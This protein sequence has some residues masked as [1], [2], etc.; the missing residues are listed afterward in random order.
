MRVY[1]YI[2]ICVS[3]PFCRDSFERT[4]P[5]P[6]GHRSKSCTPTKHPNP[7]TKLGSKMGG[8]FTD[9]PTWDPKAV[10][11]GHIFPGATPWRQVPGSCDVLQLGVR[12]RPAAMAGLLLRHCGEDAGRQGPKRG[13]K[14][15]FF[16][17]LGSLPFG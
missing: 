9:Q 3:V 16:K 13:R 4:L 2:D 11:T 12:H 8:E 17:C 6:Y 1:T 10:L 14:R 15:G 7:T 5:L